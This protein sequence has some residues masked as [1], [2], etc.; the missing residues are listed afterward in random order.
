M[1]TQACAPPYYVPYDVPFVALG[2]VKHPAE[3]TL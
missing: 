3:A 2:L 1:T